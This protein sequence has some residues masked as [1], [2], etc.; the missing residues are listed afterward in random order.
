MTDIRQE[1]IENIRKQIEELKNYK[2]KEEFGGYTFIHD[3]DHK[4]GK[5]IVVVLHKFINRNFP[6]LLV[7][8]PKTYQETRKLEKLQLSWLYKINNEMPTAIEEI[9]KKGLE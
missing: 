2:W 7:C 6:E 9:K 1:V 8:G 4:D 5:E 3:Y